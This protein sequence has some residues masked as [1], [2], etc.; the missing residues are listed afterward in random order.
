MVHIVDNYY[1][2]NNNFGYSVVRK[3]GKTNKKGEEICKTL[4]YCGNLEEVLKL[5]RNDA[6]HEKLAGSDYELTQALQMIRKE[7]DRIMNALEDIE[8]V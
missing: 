5:V 8:D 7:T 3:T 1:A 6:V 4:G 2:E